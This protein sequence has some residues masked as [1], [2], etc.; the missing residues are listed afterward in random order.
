MLG[1]RTS[2]TATV[3]AQ[4]LS[5]AESTY[6]YDPLYQPVKA[7]YSSGT[8]FNDETHEWAYDALRN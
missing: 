6:F 8:R 2:V 3:P 1:Q 4:G 7:Q 5:A